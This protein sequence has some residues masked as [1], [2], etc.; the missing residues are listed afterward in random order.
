[1]VNYKTGEV[2]IQAAKKGRGLKGL[3]NLIGCDPRQLY[4]LLSA[5]RICL[6]TADRWA[7]R[8]GTHP[9]EL[10]GDEWLEDT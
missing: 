2:V 3:A 6:W 4:R 9:Y 8:L 7:C 10:W 5:S 1:V